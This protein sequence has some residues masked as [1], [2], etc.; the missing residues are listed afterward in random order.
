MMPPPPPP[1]PQAAPRTASLRNR[2]RAAANDAP[3]R[4]TGRTPSVSAAV[5]SGRAKPEEE[6]L[7]LATAASKSLGSVLGVGAAAGGVRPS[8]KSSTSDPAKLGKVLSRGRAATV[9]K[10]SLP[11]AAD[12]AFGRAM[13]LRSR[14]GKGE[15]TTTTTTNTTAMAT[16]RTRAGTGT[17]TGK[18]RPASVYGA[19]SKQDLAGMGTAASG[20]RRPSTT[21]LTTNATISMP[22]PPPPA[23]KGHR[24]SAS[25]V[26]ATITANAATSTTATAPIGISASSRPTTAGSA[27]NKRP[28][29]S[30]LTQDFTVPANPNPP[31][32]PRSRIVPPPPL[33]TPTLH[34]QTQLL[35]LLTLRSSSAAVYQ[36]LIASATAT[37]KARFEQLSARHYDARETSAK[38]QKR[39]NIDSLAA[40]V[41]SAP[42]RSRRESTNTPEQ[43]VQAFSE[44][45][46]RI[47]AMR[48]GEFRGLCTAF[49]DWIAGY[50]PRAGSGGR[51]KWVDGIGEAWR[52]ECVG[53]CRRLEAGIVGVD[54]VAGVLAAH[55]EVEALV[56]TVS[57]VAE[58]YR[59]L[60]EGMLEE[61]EMMGRMEVEVVERER[62]QMGRRVQ[63]I[64]EGVGA[65]N[66]YT[67]QGIWA[68]C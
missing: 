17:G 26:N 8:L 7:A 49:G 57:R 67:G 9:D 46:K 28:A 45:I 50:N 20:I 12:G 2:N 33:D 5:A 55:G 13:S 1:P 19:T 14:A 62:M 63:A 3:P 56:T 40:V 16:T 32:S 6:K 61:A 60:A 10:A 39:H 43:R 37:L 25:G 36:Q 66:A 31:P 48:S 18:Q 15:G 51:E 44:A 59:D 47:D 64:L 30:A 29:F 52:R 24:R 53:V 22:P 58:G 54:G 42:G 35:Q 21:S 41:S 68:G 38:K 34:A 11:P 65:E 4:R 23:A 27:K